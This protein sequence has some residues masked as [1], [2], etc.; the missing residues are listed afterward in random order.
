[1]SDYQY[2]LVVIGGGSGGY[3]AARTAHSH[4][5]KTAVIDGADELGGLCILRGCMPSKT[6]IES[7]NRARTIREAD[8][9]GLKA[10]YHGADGPAIRARKRTLIDDFAG[11]R[12]GQLEDGRFDLHRGF[13]KF[14]SPHS[15]DVALRD[16]N[17]ISITFR[18][19]VIAAGSTISTPPIDGLQETGF[20][21]SDD[22]LDSDHIPKSIIVLGGGA[23]AME[24]A[25]YYEG[26]GVETTV[27]Q[28]SPHIL[29]DCD[30]DVAKVVEDA[31]RKRGI[32]L[33]TGTKL[34]SVTR[35][36]DGLKRV[37][38]DSENG[39][40]FAAA[41]EILCALG[42]KPN[43]S[44]LG[45]E[46]AGITTSPSGHIKVEPTQACVGQPHLF[47]VGDV[48]GPLEVV[49]LAIEQGEIAA[50]NANAMLNGVAGEPRTFSDRLKL[51]G[52]F[53]EPQIGMVGLTEKEA[54]A[55]GIPYDVADYPFDD[56]GKSM[57]M[58]E[59]HGFVKLLAHR[60][61]KEIIGGAVVGP[62]ASE[63]IHE[64]VVA[65]RF[66]ATAEQLAT[67]PHY[68]PTL[69]EIWTYPAEDLAD[70]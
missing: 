52:V 63:L 27:I 16:G 46:A 57:V 37:H 7:A 55:E 34:T 8:A 9:F 67:T 43:T 64:V 70:L 17:Q 51:F 59:L 5:L 4:G 14:T 48:C 40:Q 65:M 61:T 44:P 2:D 24:L 49:H 26:L 32:N 54:K 6:L 19:A 30:S 36:E 28:R 12:Q 45:L 39:P 25:H 18:S 56:H 41:E 66:R 60:E 35:D 22:V 15:L 1:M 33:F 68:H 23:I 21:T 11:Y 3:A 69:S 58:G 38:F 31:S 29:K 20:L 50:D 10:S 62:H 13:A 47:A 42:R 53:T